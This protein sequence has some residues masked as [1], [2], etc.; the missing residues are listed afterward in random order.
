MN[1]A[2]RFISQTNTSVFL[3]GKAGTGKTTFLRRLHELTPKRMVVLAPT[4]VAAINAQGQTIHSFFQLPLGPLVPG[5]A[6]TERKKHFRMSQ[7]KKNL[8]RT[9]DLLI[10]DEI[11]MVR[12]D[13]L[14][15]IRPHVLALG[16]GS[17]SDATIFRA[18]CARPLRDG[19]AAALANGDSAQADTLLASVL[20]AG[21]DFSTKE[22]LNAS[23]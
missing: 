1:L 22:I 20:P 8:I 19:L 13:L 21:I 15:A 6:N 10:I 14:D 7:D 11:S 3:T 16:L 4:G 12:A 17:D 23:D 18:I 5:E 9:L 2:W